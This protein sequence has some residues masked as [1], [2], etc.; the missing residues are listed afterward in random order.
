MMTSSAD[1]DD[2]HA[3]AAS[4][5]ITTGERLFG[6]VVITLVDDP[7][8]DSTYLSAKDPGNNRNIKVEVNI[9]TDS[10]TRQIVV[11]K[12]EDGV[13]LPLSTMC[14]SG[15]FLSVMQT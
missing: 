9:P 1:G 14:C 6:D 10:S 5:K 4:F 8:H 11:S 15:W 7:K 3:T 12:T 13:T 2:N